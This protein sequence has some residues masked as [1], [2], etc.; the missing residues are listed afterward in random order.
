M[1]C[2]RNGGVVSK[3]K[4]AGERKKNERNRVSEEECRSNPTAEAPVRS[5]RES[6]IQTEVGAD[7]L[8]LRGASG[9]LPLLLAVGR[10][11]RERLDGRAAA[12]LA[13]ATSEGGQAL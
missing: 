1:L 11:A 3:G 5:G 2:K 4:I 10:A 7:D 8:D 9:D 13:V 12:E 6:E